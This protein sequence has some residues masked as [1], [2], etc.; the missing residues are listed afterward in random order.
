MDKVPIKVSSK[1]ANFVD[2]F[3][4]RLATELPKYMRINNYTIEL[5]NDWQPPYNSIYSLGLVRL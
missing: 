4:P 2:I 1:Y 3:L 5:V